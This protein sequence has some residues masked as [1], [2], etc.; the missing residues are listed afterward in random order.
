MNDQKID[1]RD[2]SPFSHPPTSRVDWPFEPAWLGCCNGTGREAPDCAQRPV[3]LR[4]RGAELG[5]VDRH[6]I[7]DAA[8]RPD[9][10]CSRAS[11][12]RAPPGHASEANRGFVQKLVAQATIETLDKGVLLWLAEGDIMPVDAGF[13]RPAQDRH[14][15]Q[16]G[17]IVGDASNRLAAL[18]ADRIELASDPKDGERG[19]CDKRQAFAGEV[20]EGGEDA[21][22][23]AIAQLIMQEIQRPAVVRTLRQCQ[24]ANGT[25][26]PSARL[27]PPRRASPFFCCHVLQHG[28]VEHCLG[29]KPL[30]LGVLVLERAFS[31]RASDTSIP[32]YLAFHL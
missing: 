21:K 13:L 16:L 14:A 15:G 32:P 6:Q 27:R 26:L 11:I 1:D 4:C 29:Q 18:G 12:A 31:R 8:V 5:V 23:P 30:Q 3:P 22:P 17:A 19:I 24:R 7:S 25:L 20:V 2:L 28:V 10:C 9:W